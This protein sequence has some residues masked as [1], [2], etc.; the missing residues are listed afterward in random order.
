MLQTAEDHGLY[1]FVSGSKMQGTSYEQVK[2]AK[3][4]FE[5]DDENILC[6]DDII[7]IGDLT[8]VLDPDDDVRTFIPELSTK[9]KCVANRIDIYNPPQET[10]MLRPKQCWLI[11][12]I[13]SWYVVE[14]L[15]I[16]DGRIAVR[17]WDLIDCKVVVLFIGTNIYNRTYTCIGTNI[18]NRT[19]TCFSNNWNNA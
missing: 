3:E 18:Y 14:F 2:T 16:V 6:C 4:M 17:K 8:Q 5:Q 11:C 19:Y 10:L 7:T 12:N 13:R 1:L 15:G 9:Y